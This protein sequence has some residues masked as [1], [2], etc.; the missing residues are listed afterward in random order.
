MVFCFYEVLGVVEGVMIDKVVDFVVFFV[1]GGV[2]FV[3]GFIGFSWVVVIFKD[4]MLCSLWCV[5]N[6]LKCM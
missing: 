2:L 3:V 4:D 5:F 1:V 6:G